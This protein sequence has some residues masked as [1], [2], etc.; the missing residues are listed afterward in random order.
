[1]IRAIEE[2]AKSFR[3]GPYIRKFVNL[4]IEEF[5][6]IQYEG[7]RDLNGMYQDGRFTD[8]RD[9]GI[10]K[11]RV[12]VERPCFPAGWTVDVEFAADH[13]QFDEHIL[14]R[15]LD[16]AGKYVGV[17]TARILG[18]GRFAWSVVSK[19]EIAPPADMVIIEED[20]EEESDDE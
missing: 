5:S 16:Y 18:F 14:E 6:P 4:G 20:D 10:Q 12:M 3:A 9:V 11:K 7:P 2:G 15:S 8:R 19:H 13:A 17:G 1:V